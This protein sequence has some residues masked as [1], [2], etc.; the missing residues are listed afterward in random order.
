MRELS[1]STQNIPTP[2][3]EEQRRLLLLKQCAESDRKRELKLAKDMGT[4]GNEY[5]DL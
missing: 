1:V 5:S 4:S 2:G 3:R